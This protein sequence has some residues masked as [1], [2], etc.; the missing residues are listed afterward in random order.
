M[1]IGRLPATFMQKLSMKGIEKIFSGIENGYLTVTYPDS[2]IKN[3][4]NHDSKEKAD[5][6][7]N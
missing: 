6:T 4:G 2:S 1:T 5:I 3:F 7:I